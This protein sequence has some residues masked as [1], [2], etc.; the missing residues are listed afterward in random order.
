MP[1]PVATV[2]GEPPRDAQPPA[3]HSRDTIAAI[4]HGLLAL[5]QLSGLYESPY[6][7]SQVRITLCAYR[8]CFVKQAWY[9]TTEKTGPRR[10]G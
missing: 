6:E 7:E 5:K 2:L 1:T 9:L 8:L 4:Q 3:G 10:S